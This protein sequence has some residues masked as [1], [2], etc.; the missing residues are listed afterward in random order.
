M[1]LISFLIQ[2]F[3]K[4]IVSV[5]HLGGLLVDAAEADMRAPL[6]H[7]GLDRPY[8]TL[9]LA[10]VPLLTLIVTIK[11]MGG[12]MRALMIV[13]MVAALARILWP[14]IAEASLAI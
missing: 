9:I 12:F 5:G 3:A 2:L 8:Q 1:L 4:T 7:M 13:S 6:Q 14:F 10:L 11:L